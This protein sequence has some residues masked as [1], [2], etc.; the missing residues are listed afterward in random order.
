MSLNCSPYPDKL[1][2]IAFAYSK[3]KA[4]LKLVGE[5]YTFNVTVLYKTTMT[6]AMNKL[7]VFH[8]TGIKAPQS[9][10]VTANGRA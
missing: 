1:A 10:A 3:Y 4:V 6:I 2:A 8:A 9:F 5:P 7:I